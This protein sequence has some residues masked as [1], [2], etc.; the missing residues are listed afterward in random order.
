MPLASA[1]AAKRIRHSPTPQ[2]SEDPRRYQDGFLVRRQVRAQVPRSPTFYMKP[3]PSHASPRLDQHIETPPASDVDSDN[4]SGFFERVVNWL[5]SPYRHRKRR[6]IP[7]SQQGQT[8]KT[9]VDRAAQT[10][11]DSVFS[12]SSTSSESDTDTE[13]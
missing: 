13:K 6:G 4:E 2:H 1:V 12:A 8:L 10:D 7:R 5:A 11:T 3:T 9:T